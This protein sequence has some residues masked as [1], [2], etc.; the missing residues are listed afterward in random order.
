M[1]QRGTQ[2]RGSHRGFLL[3]VVIVCIVLAGLAMVGVARHSLRLAEDAV[4]AQRELQLR[5]GAVSC[6]RTLLAVAPSL[7]TGL[8]KRHRDANTAGPAPSSAR[9][10]ILLGGVRFEMLVADEDAKANLNTIYHRGGRG[11]AEGAAR[12]LSA[13][14]LLPVWLVPELASSAS[15]A[16]RPRP[17][18]ESEDA[19]PVPP[20]FNHW[21]QVFDLARVPPVIDATTAL[22]AATSRLTCWGRGRVNIARAPDDALIE[23]CRVAISE[24]AA[25]RLVREYRET[26]LRGIP[27]LISLAGVRP[28]EAADLAELLGRESYCYSVWVDAA[29]PQRRMHSL[30]VAERDDNGALRTWRYEF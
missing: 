24:T 28:R 4:T 10:R 13:N 1:R 25:R 17:Q 9:A 15:Q 18:E 27:Q 12:R 14:P 16:R 20:A 22:P 30:A 3:L 23:V 26:P 2:F 8:E 7:F 5:W 6:Q 19:P 29:T 11:A 21:G